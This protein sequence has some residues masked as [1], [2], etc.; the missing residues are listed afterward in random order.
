[1]SASESTGSKQPQ[2]DA[3]PLF[4][5]AIVGVVGDVTAAELGV[6]DAIKLRTAHERLTRLKVLVDTWAKQQ[7]E[8]RTLRKA[9]AKALMI[10]LCAEVVAIFI[11]FGLVATGVFHVEPW[12][13]DA[14]LMTAFLQSVSLVLV[15]VKYL[16][17]NRESEVLKILELESRLPSAAA[18]KL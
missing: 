3:T 13:A 4:N 18:T 2:G 7:D 10:L 17:P 15:V 1:M 6:D 11:A 9:Y 8:E 12:V 5:A 16:F 14:F